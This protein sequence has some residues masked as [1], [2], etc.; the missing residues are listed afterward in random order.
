LEA[1]LRKQ[2]REVSV[3]F[4]ARAALRVLPFA[5]S[6][7][8]DVGYESFLG[9][10]VFRAISVAWAGAKYP[11]QA[12]R[13]ASAARATAPATQVAARAAAANAALTAARTAARAAAALE[14]TAANA[15]AAR[16]FAIALTAIHGATD[17][18][19]DVSGRFINPR[20]PAY[21]NYLDEIFRRG[22]TAHYF[23]EAFWSAVSIDAKRE[24]ESA[25]P[26]S[27]AGSPLWPDGPPEQFRSLLQEM[28]GALLGAKED[29][30][31]WTTWYDDRHEGRVRDEERE[32]AYV[33]IEE[34]LWAQGPAIVNAEI[35]R[36]IEEF[37]PPQHDVVQVQARISSSSS[38][39]AGVSLSVAE[40]AI[41]AVPIDNP[42]IAGPGA[43]PLSEFSRHGNRRMR[44]CRRRIRAVSTSR[45]SSS[46][47]SAPRRWR[48]HR[49]LRSKPSRNK[50]H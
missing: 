16:T 19:L 28:K 46:T 23:A 17:E 3:A 13:F 1:W 10:P 27:I 43:Q 41:S 15:A 18:I 29:W 44:R 24:E 9:L 12:V 49:P 14:P 48:I 31:V 20:S 50:S 33:R 26:S 36:R 25:V 8:S 4:A 22:T 45:M 35:K 47:A 34:A 39:S 42:P 30:D 11:A 38:M 21:G 32:L 40:P 6:A 2:P 7:R 37:E 5:N